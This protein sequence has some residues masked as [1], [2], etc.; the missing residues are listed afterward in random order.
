MET[1]QLQTLPPP[2]GIVGSLKA[3][4][5]TIAS[6]VVVILL[7]LA[8]DLWLWLGPHL[9]VERLFKT[10]FDEMA[11]YS[12]TNGLPATEI[13]TTP[14][15]YTALLGELSKFNLMSLLRTFPV[16]VFSLMSG[17]MPTETPFGSATMVYVDS[18]LA[19][20]G[21]TFLLTLA[22]WVLGGVFFRWV[23]FVVADPSKPTAL[24]LGYCVTQT[25]LFSTL[26]LLLIFLL[27]IPLSMALAVLLLISPAL[28]QGLVLI[29]GLLS[30]WLVVPL[31]FTPHGIF[32]RQENM[33]TSIY[34]S[35]RMA[36]FTLPT[37]SLFVLTVFLIA[38]GLDYL[39]NIPA[40]NSWMALVGIA[41]HAFITTSL[42]AASFIYYRDMQVW[43]QT[44]FAKMKANTPTQSA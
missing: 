28:A 16:G 11:Q 36:R 17:K 34:T 24:R 14:E 27:G 13:G 2:P 22:G 10:L 29:V 41:G 5:D 44:V 42:L 30:M 23:S 19:L 12:A 25:V 35:L 6:N 4:F 20:A 32:L 9:R 31:F 18:P 21:W 40:A 7:P 39:W 15:M 3:G 1:E 33:L 37:S 38:Y 26:W 43:L 8:L